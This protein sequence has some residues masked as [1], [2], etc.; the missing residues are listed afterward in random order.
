MKKFELKK[1][2]SMIKKIFTTIVMILV[3]IYIFTNKSD[4]ADFQKYKEVNFN[5]Y[6]IIK[7]AEDEDIN[8]LQQHTNEGQATSLEQNGT[9]TTYGGGSSAQPKISTTNIVTEATTAIVGLFVYVITMGIISFGF[10][11]IPEAILKKIK[12]FATN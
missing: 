5:D 1:G 4:A 6:G 12:L 3:I 7:V 10:T 9:V 11:I 2:G 8:E